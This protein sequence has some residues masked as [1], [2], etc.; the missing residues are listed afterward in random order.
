VLQ[1]DDNEEII[2]NVIKILIANE[3]NECYS[4]IFL[5]INHIKGC[6]GSINKSQKHLKKS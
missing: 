1:K 2:T 5:A 6:S 3:I 4:V